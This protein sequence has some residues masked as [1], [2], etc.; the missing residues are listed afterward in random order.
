MYIYIYMCRYIADYCPEAP[1]H[2]GASVS[3]NLWQFI[4]IGECVHPR[5]A[6]PTAT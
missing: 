3:A 1:E 6:R 4:S 5:W 2:A